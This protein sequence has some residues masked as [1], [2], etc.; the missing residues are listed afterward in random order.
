MLKNRLI[1]SRLKV[2]F[3]I[4]SQNR[5]NVIVRSYCKL[6]VVEV[7]LKNRLKVFVVTLRN[8]LKA[9]VTLKNM[10]KVLVV[11]SKNRMKMIAI[12]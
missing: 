3:V 11:I 7:P 5:T 6:K 9:V 4:I 8:M 1:V 12:A 2:D 10:L